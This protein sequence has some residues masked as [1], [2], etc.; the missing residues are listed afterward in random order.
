[1]TCRDQFG[2]P[3]TANDPDALRHYDDAVAKLLTFSGDPVAEVDAATAG[4]PALVMG[5]VLKGL[6]FVLG[7]EKSLLPDARAALEAGM[8]VAGDA[9]EREARHLAA[10]E[11][12][13]DG[14]LHDACST[15][16]TI[17]VDQPDDAL[18][19]LAAH[20]GDFFLGQSTEL[21][22]RVARRL[23]SIDRGSRLEGY[24]LGMHAF[25]LEETGD[26]AA[27]ELAG[28]LAVERDRRDAWAIHAVA[29]VMEMTNR[30][31]DGRS[32]LESRTDDWARDS[33]FAV[34]N[35]WHLAL[36]YFDQQR[37][38]Q[39]L[40]L[41]DRSVRGSD[42]AVILDMLDASSLLWRLKLHG[43]DV[44]ERWQPL[45]E[46]WEP[47]IDDGWYAFNDTH[48]M[49]AFAGAGRTDLAQRLLEVMQRT[50]SLPTDNGAMTRTVALPVAHA[51]LAH[52]ERRYSDVV[53]LLLPVRS[54]AAR[55]GGSH[56]Q[57]D[58][59]A[60]TL[61]SAAELAGQRSLARALLNERLAIKP[62]SALNMAWSR[63]IASA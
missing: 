33:F 54:I 12:W 18:A 51:M 42:S 24:Y 43:I 59:I 60:Q 47:R 19:M 21:R 2:V 31:E 27:A 58:L 4:D 5:H 52:A 39:V 6:L 32:W 37:W 15:W 7:T 41:Y 30:V 28:R 29:H 14:R 16:E 20:Q 11:C 46:A 25:G 36:F 13:I 40:E 55:A 49:M 1:M 10:L 34:H 17:L 53:E 22:D 3:L 38:D 56:A 48:A 8:Q 9:T 44:G 63:R 62:R 45:A 57:R 61:T 35:W 50:A 26:Y 23:G